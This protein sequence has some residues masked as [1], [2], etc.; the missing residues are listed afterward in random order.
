MK[1]KIYHNINIFDLNKIL[2]IIHDRILLDKLSSLF[3]MK[4]NVKL[5][6]WRRTGISCFKNKNMRSLMKY[7]SEDEMINIL[8]TSRIGSYIDIIEDAVEKKWDRLIR[9]MGNR[10]VHKL[11]HHVKD[12]NIMQ[13]LMYILQV[14]PSFPISLRISEIAYDI[15]KIEKPNLYTCNIPSYVNVPVFGRVE[16]YRKMLYN[17][18]RYEGLKISCTNGHSNRYI[19][20]ILFMLILGDSRRSA[21]YTNNHDYIVNIP[22]MDY[23]AYEYPNSIMMLW[24]KFAHKISTIKNTCILNY[25]GYISG[26][27]V[28][29]HWKKYYRLHI[30]RPINFSDIII[31]DSNT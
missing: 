19:H 31:K 16:Y 3:I 10:I 1:E 6:L 11:T 14:C 24:N 25:P 21:L 28:S 29:S 8:S 15:P 5:E 22:I 4:T 7:A 27:E 23:L 26:D 12:D 30:L 17:W 2:D 9:Y 20:H 13:K 18:K